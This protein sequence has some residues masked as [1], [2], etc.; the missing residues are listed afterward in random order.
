MQSSVAERSCQKL[1]FKYFG[2][3]LVLQRVGQVAYKLQLPP[4]ARIHPVVHVSQLKKAIPTNAQVCTG[5]PNYML[6]QVMVYP[7]HIKQDR[8]VRRGRKVVP[9]V[10]L[11]WAGLPAECT[12]WEPLF[13]MVNAYPSSPAWGHAGTP[14]GG[15]AM[16]TAPYLAQAVKAKQRTDARSR[17][18]KAHLLSSGANEARKL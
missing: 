18:R 10:L 2:P 6:S 12:T 7:L 8:L 9:Q 15:N 17:I 5:L 4:S 3:Y 13:A 16:V 11:R 1:S 14:G